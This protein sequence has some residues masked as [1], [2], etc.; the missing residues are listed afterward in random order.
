MALA[1]R[2]KSSHTFVFSTEAPEGERGETKTVNKNHT[3]RKISAF[4]VAA[5]MLGGALLGPLA[6]AAQAQSARQKDKNLMR[7]LG[8]GLG[9]AAVWQATKGKTTNALIL[10]AGAAYAGKKYED[11]RKAQA[12]ENSTRR[13]Y[14]YSNGKQIGYY[15]YRGNKRISYTRLR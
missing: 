10:G 8:I 2:H 9:A 3:I 7:N 14:R 4:G 11:A 15:T 5:T 13:V 6:G 1:L 12:K